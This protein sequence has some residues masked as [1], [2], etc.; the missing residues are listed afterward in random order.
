MP[1]QK[2]QMAEMLA[3]L[4]D[5]DRAESMI[6][7]TLEHE[8]GYVFNPKDP[9]GETKFGI[10]K[11]WYPDIDIKNLQRAQAKEIL[12][13]DYYEKA[14]IGEI[15]NYELANKMF[16]LGVNLGPGTVAKLMQQSLIEQGQQVDKVDAIL[17]S[18][19][20]KAIN[21]FPDQEVLLSTFK[22]Q[23]KAYYES[24]GHKK[25]FIKGWLA[26]LEE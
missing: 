10:T 18:K 23:A 21:K 2:V 8:K 25:D 7:Q 12:R 6:E 19:T 5:R 26:R 24:L 14:R 1:N 4:A 13:K 20:I 22:N 9:G 11:R 16:D 17:G 15:S 3:S